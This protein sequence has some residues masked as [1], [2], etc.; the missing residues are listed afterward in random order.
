MAS[1]GWE[2]AKEWTEFAN[3]ITPTI[4]SGSKKHGGADLGSTRSKLAWSKLD[5]NSH[6]PDEMSPTK[7]F[8]GMPKL[9]VKMA[10]LIQGV[11]TDWIFVGKKMPAY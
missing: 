3:D 5:V 9:I 1:N 10:A 11:P 6:G 4:V 7:E 2:G 8:T